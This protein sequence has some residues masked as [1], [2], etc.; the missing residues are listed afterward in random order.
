MINARVVQFRRGRRTITPNHI[1]IEITGVDSKEKTKEYVGRKV[2]WESTAKK[3]ISGEIV[4]A[5]GGKGI[6]RAIFQS[7]L[8]GQAIGSEIKI[9]GAKN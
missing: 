2:E 6:V 1:L 8:P 9:I 3:I 7:G 5:H 4:S